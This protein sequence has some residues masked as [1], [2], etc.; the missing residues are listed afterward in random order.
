MEYDSNN[1]D[2]CDYCLHRHPSILKRYALELMFVAEWATLCRWPHCSSTSRP[3]SR[4]TATFWSFCWDL[5]E[6][7]RQTQAQV[8]MLIYL[9]LCFLTHP[10]LF[11]SH[12]VWSGLSIVSRENFNPLC[13]GFNF[14]RV[15]MVKSPKRLKRTTPGLNEPAQGIW[16]SNL[17]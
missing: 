11:I 15:R 17:S 3:V 4:S 10:G 13:T 7:N 14:K 1:C 8:V 5:V 12:L 9:G 16:R 2:M 6:Q